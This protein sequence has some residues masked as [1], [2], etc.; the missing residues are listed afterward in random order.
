[1]NAF[2]LGATGLVGR[3]ILTFL[4]ASDEYDCI[5]A[6][7]RR[8]TGCASEKLNEIP[9]DP[10]RAENWTPAVDI[11][12]AFIAFGT[13]KKRA[14]GIDAQREIDLHMP[15]KYVKRMREIGVRH[16]SL[17]SSLGA[18]WKSNNAYS[19]MKGQLEEDI[20]KMGFP[21]FA[22][23]RPSVLGGSRPDDE[24][25]LEEWAQRAMSWLPKSLRT[26]PA[27]RV[28]AAMVRTAGREPEGMR[29]IPSNKIWDISEPASK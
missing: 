11:D 19:A 21:S 2:L 26:I 29:V 18:D 15:L 3:H 25:P 6:P 14:G 17:C 8:T 20:R 9:F 27:E 16:V 7:V 22:T 13:T 23:F 4:L 28:A 10:D 1:M 24:R 12:H 5:V